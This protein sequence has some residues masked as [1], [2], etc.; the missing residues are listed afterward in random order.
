MLEAW[1]LSQMRSGLL[2]ERSYWKGLTALEEK[3]R[4]KNMKKKIRN[5]FTIFTVHNAGHGLRT[6]NQSYHQI[7]SQRNPLQSPGCRQKSLYNTWALTWCAATSST[8]L[9]HH[10][11]F[12]HS[13]LGRRNLL[14]ALLKSTW[15][16]IYP[17]STTPHFMFKVQ[18]AV[19]RKSGTDV[20]DL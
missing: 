15:L 1:I 14:S 18:L 6:K 17:G 5:N 8:E 3:A 13:R 16:C 9:T 20:P 2:W 4:Y 7:S 12:F 10:R 19:S 11:R